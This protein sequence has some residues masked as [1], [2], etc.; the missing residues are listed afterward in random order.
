MPKLTMNNVQLTDGWTTT[1]PMQ[2]RNFVIVYESKT[3]L[4]CITEDTVSTQPQ[5]EKNKNKPVWQI[6][7]Y[8]FTSPLSSFSSKY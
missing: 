5:M 6:S 3:C 7:H 1:G 4:K 8:S 2:G